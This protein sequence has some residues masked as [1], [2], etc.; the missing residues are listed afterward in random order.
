MSSRSCVF[1]RS[2]CF[3]RASD[4]LAVHS[5][6][7]FTDWTVLLRFTQHAS[8]LDLML[9]RCCILASTRRRRCELSSS[10]LVSST[11]WRSTAAWSLRVFCVKMSLVRRCVS[12]MR[13]MSFI[14][15]AC[16]RAIRL[17]RSCRSASARERACFAS[18]IWLESI[19]CCTSEKR[20]TSELASPSI[21]PESPG[22][23]GLPKPG[24]SLM[25]SSSP[26]LET[27]L[28]VCFLFVFWQPRAEGGAR[29][30]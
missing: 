4:S 15:S 3:R 7:S 29:V 6:R 14:S 8:W 20:D 19:T 9:C 12:S 25:R 23:S 30:V 28:L 18:I 2:S 27:V 5:L 17:R 11:V 10:L 22:G 26:T 13:F 16:R 1:S 24:A 21:T